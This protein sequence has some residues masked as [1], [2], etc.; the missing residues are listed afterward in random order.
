M[1]FGTDPSEDSTVV[2]MLAAAIRRDIAFGQLAPDQKLKIDGLRQRY[3]GSNHSMREALRLLHAEGIVE[4]ESQRGFRVTS[5]T[6]GDLRD[7]V[8]MR[9]EI[10]RIG[11]QRSIER[12]SVAWE[13]RVIAALHAVDRAEA[14]LN[15]RAEDA[16]ALLWDEACRAA[17]ATL[18]EACGSPRMIETQARF[19]NQSRR[20]RLAA[21]REGRIDFA[22]RADHRD[23][24]R[25][26]VLDHDADAA[27]GALEMEIRAEAGDDPTTAR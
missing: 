23:A 20:F 25:R 27:V 6:A 16:E 17:S 14:A 19:Y 9:L 11:L 5:A 22:A 21:L 13:G 26:A 1:L 18:I 10:E 15:D 4:A 3:G 8:L 2:A 24:L 12:S 7:I